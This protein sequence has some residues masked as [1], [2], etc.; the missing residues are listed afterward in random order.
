MSL[1]LILYLVYAIGQAVGVAWFVWTEKKGDVLI[2]A[3]WAAVAP[4]LTIILFFMYK[5]SLK[6]RLAT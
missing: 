5:N 3:F 2:L 4:V 6:A 1:Y